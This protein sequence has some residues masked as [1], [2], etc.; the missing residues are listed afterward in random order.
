MDAGEIARLSG[1]E[2]RVSAGVEIEQLLDRYERP[3]YAYLLTLLGDPDTAR[4]CTQDAF[5]R[6]LEQLRRGKEINGGWLYTV[7]RNRAIDH[8]RDRRRVGPE[9]VTLEMDLEAG[10]GEPFHLTAVRRI[11]DRLSPDDREALYLFSV[12]GFRTDEIAAML[13]IQPGAL[14]VR[15]SRAR[16]RFRALY[17]EES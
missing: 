17:E 7:G 14:R 3:L 4:D 6:A 2:I 16:Q 11:L 9:D 10:Q 5:L 15:L 13:G 12:D 1:R 8:L